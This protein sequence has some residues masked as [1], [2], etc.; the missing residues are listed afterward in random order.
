MNEAITHRDLSWAVCGWMLNASWCSAATIEI[1]TLKHGNADVMALGKPDKAPKFVIGEV[2]R[3]RSDLLADL[4]A[5]KM[6]KYGKLA[7]HCYLALCNDCMA[8]ESAGIIG[9]LTRLGLPERWGVLWVSETRTG[10]LHVSSLRTAKKLQSVPGSLIEVY[11]RTFARSL[12]WRLQR[13]ES[14]LR[15]SRL[16]EASLQEQL[17]ARHV[18]TVIPAPFLCEAPDCDARMGAQAE[19]DPDAPTCAMG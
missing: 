9:E 7:S 14:E 1:G 4:R 18:E 3:Y 11:T 13:V 19:Q 15:R 17:H 2:K 10:G 8:G 6:L 16:S 12:T 5:G